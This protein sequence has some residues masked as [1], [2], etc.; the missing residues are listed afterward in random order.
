MIQEPVRYAAE[1][2]GDLIFTIRG[3][4]V[5]L[6]ADLAHIYGVPTKKA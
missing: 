2:L 1:S 3:Q 4:Q 5:I 6:D